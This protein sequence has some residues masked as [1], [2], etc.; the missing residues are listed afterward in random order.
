MQI[1]HKHKGV[2][3]GDALRRPGVT[4]DGDAAR[5]AKPIEKNEGAAAREKHG[6]SYE[7]SRRFFRPRLRAVQDEP[8][9]VIDDA[10]DQI[11]EQNEIQSR[12]HIAVLIGKAGVNGHK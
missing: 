11:A 5:V 8:N 6:L 4:V 9:D 10:R 12:Q 2:R 7:V 3:P 1:R